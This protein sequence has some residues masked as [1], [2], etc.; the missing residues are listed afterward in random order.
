MIRAFLGVEMP[1][2]V[3]ASL[4]V[5]QFLLPLPRREPVEN[6]HLTLVFLGEIPELTLVAAHEGFAAI[7]MQ[8]FDL[9]LSGLG[10]FGG[11]RPR[12]AWAGVAPSEPLVRLQAKAVRAADRAGCATDHRRFVPHVTLG[13]FRP[14]PAPEA[15]SLE[16]A[17]AEGA[18]FRAGPFRVAETV[19]FRSHSGAKGH[20]YE[21]L[22]RYPLA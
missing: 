13:R 20:W 5:Q 17:I 15:M 21:P 8:A 11:D 6:L 16:R 10:L 12:A 1:E 18:G 14:P 3:R 22:A 19:L 4:A 9:T 2:A 7:R